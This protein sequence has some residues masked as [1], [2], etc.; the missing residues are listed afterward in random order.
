MFVIVGLR[1]KAAINSNR[2]AG[3]TVSQNF[4]RKIW[5]PPDLLEPR[6]DSDRIS[7]YSR[8]DY[9]IGETS[10]DVL[11]SIADRL[12]NGPNPVEA[13]PELSS[14]DIEFERAESSSTRST[15]IKDMSGA[16]VF[17]LAADEP[18]FE[19]PGSERAG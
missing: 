17:E 2:W 16:P 14:T 5:V 13:L 11:R 1:P 3:R 10:Q 7:H 6:R 19:L 9:V 8:K 4:H 15:N 12:T 18:R